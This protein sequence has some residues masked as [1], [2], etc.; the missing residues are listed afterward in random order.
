MQGHAWLGMGVWWLTVVCGQLLLKPHLKKP[1]QA[2]HAP[3]HSCSVHCVERRHK[4]PTPAADAAVTM[5]LLL[6]LL[7]QK[8]WLFAG[9]TAA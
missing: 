5:L 8:A 9:L 7:A 1:H 4:A 2:A 6:L 3:E